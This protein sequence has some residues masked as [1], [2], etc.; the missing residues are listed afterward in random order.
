MVHSRLGVIKYVFQIK[1]KVFPLKQSSRNAPEFLQHPMA[2]R[3]TAARKTEVV[4]DRPKAFIMTLGK[5]VSVALCV[6]FMLLLNT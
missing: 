6:H 1:M 2:A 5:F 4:T 3:V